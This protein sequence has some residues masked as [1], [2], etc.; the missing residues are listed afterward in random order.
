MKRGKNARDPSGK[1]I[2][3]ESAR[4]IQVLSFVMVEKASGAFILRCVTNEDVIG[5]IKKQGALD[6]FLTDVDQLYTDF[7]KRFEQ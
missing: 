7:K 5:D 1:G 2:K 6:K 3:G 4:E